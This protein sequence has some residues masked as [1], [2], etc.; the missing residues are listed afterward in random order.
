MLDLLAVRR[1][2]RLVVMEIKADEDL[3]L[4]LQALDYWVRVRQHHL[5]AAGKA[6]SSDS[7]SDLERFGYFPGRQLRADA[8]LLYL[9]A[10]AL[11]IHPATEVVLRYIS[12]EVDWTLIALDERWREKIR[13][14]FRKRREK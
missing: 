12:P 5:S 2:G 7:N 6:G 1:D 8:P 4:A 14:V 10:P 9:I 13:V 11:R 3:H